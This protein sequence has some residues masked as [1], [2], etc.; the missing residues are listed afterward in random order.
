MSEINQEKTA[1]WYTD[2]KTT[3]KVNP[4]EEIPAGFSPGRIF[5]SNP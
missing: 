5:K 4:G 2:G 1:K 3:I